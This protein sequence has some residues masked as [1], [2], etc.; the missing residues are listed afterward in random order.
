M[1]AS[2]DIAVHVNQKPTEDVVDAGRVCLILMWLIL[3]LMFL[4]IIL[5]ALQKSQVLLGRLP[6]LLIVILLLLREREKFIQVPLQLLNIVAVLYLFH[7]F[8]LLVVLDVHALILILG[9]LGQLG[10]LW[11]AVVFGL[12]VGVQRG[13][14][15]VGL[16][17]VAGKVAP[18]LVVPCPSLALEVIVVEVEPLALGG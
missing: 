14:A 10:E 7:G 18:V 4:P 2:A 3:L 1:A 11:L 13:V 17:A 9:V 15:E 5:D 8:Y 6:R 12:D 16:A